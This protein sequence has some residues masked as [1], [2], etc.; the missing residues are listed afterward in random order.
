LAF[1]WLGRV[2]SIF[3]PETSDGPRRRSCLLDAVVECFVAEVLDL[4]V[5][6][7]L[8]EAGRSL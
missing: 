8:P 6:A 1:V 2:V 7:Q 5:A 4:P 3:R